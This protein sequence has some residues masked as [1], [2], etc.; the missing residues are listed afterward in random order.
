M[1]L[2]IPHSST[3][4]PDNAMFDKHIAADLY[5]MTDW[6][7]HK[8][9]SYPAMDAIVFPYS[10]LFCDVER[11]VDNEPMEA[12][13]HGICYTKDAYGNHLRT[14]TDKEKFR[15]I[16]N[17]YKPHHAKLNKACNNALTLFNKV[18]IVDCH[19][20]SNTVLHHES[21]KSTDRPD[22]CIGTDKFHTPDSLVRDIRDYLKSE[23]YTT[24]INDPF[25]GTIVPLDHYNKTSNLKSIMIEVN[26]N[27]YMGS[28][29]QF[30]ETKSVITKILNIINRYEL[31]QE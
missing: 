30:D 20:F 26:R 25:A 9:F 8:L 31:S 18:V 5:W 21:G 29:V 7:T 24:K 23:G 28:N 12:F 16:E 1:I 15:I 11:L 19:S 6:H 4:I 17:Y 14:V 22:F 27:L 10:R 13:G 2:H 3:V